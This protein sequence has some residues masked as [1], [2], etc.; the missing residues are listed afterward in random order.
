M[1]VLVAVDVGYLIP[2]HINR[3]ILY[4]L[5]L[6]RMLRYVSKKNIST[7]PKTNIAHFQ[8]LVGPSLFSR[9]ILVSGRVRPST[10]AP[11]KPWAP[12]DFIRCTQWWSSGGVWKN[13]LKHKWEVAFHD[14]TRIL[15]LESWLNAGFS[16]NL[17]VNEFFF[18][19]WNRENC[20][21]TPPKLADCGFFELTGSTPCKTSASVPAAVDKTD[22]KKQPARRPM[23]NGGVFKNIQS[24]KK[25][26]YRNY[27]LKKGYSHIQY[28]NLYFKDTMISFSM[29]WPQ[30]RVFEFS[31][32]YKLL[33]L[34]RW[35]TWVLTLQWCFVAWTM[36][37]NS[38]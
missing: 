38:L 18:G 27:F 1:L 35:L 12:L 28:S 14:E 20:K 3:Y 23:E 24:S 36:A 34:F 30:S 9:D 17:Q 26:I 16:K 31:D 10:W 8:F 33:Q 13:M 11:K 22:S 29:P 19:D 2:H 32:R 37:R 7:F 21:K 15:R 4:I 5:K 6:T 25:R